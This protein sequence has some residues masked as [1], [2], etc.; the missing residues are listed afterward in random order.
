M[1]GNEAKTRVFLA[2]GGASSGLRPHQSGGGGIGRATL[3]QYTA[4]TQYLY[5]L[6]IIFY[7]NLYDRY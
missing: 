4:A 6:L 1:M 2:S 5:T 7:D 3:G